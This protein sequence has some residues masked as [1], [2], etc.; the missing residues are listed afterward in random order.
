MV[1]KYATLLSL[2]DIKPTANRLLIAQALDRASM[3]LSMRELENTI[4][5]IDKSSIFRTLMLFKD[6][7]LVHTIDD[8]E[9]G[10]KYELC[11][12]HDANT[13]DDEH[14]H[15]YCEECHSTI[16][17]PDMP[18]PQVGVPEGCELHRLNIVMRGICSQCME[19]RRRK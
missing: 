19:R 11:R 10:I 6:C 17:L 18:M 14:M 1:D 8:G 4:I 12:S 13:D 7:H 16:C 15:F 9:G 2:H 3:P 5:S